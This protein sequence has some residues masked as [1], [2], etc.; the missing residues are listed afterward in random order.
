MRRPGPA[1]ANVLND[2]ARED[3]KV[4]V[5]AETGGCFETDVTT[6]GD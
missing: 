4:A 3:E 5:A 6:A 2:D 1:R